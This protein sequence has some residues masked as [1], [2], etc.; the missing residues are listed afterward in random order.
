MK[1]IQTMSF[2]TLPVRNLEGQNLELP[3]GFESDRTIAIVA[4]QRWHQSLVDSWLP[5]LKELQTRQPEVQ[6]YEIPVLSSMYMFMR[7]MI[8]GGMAAAIPS[9]EV[10]ARTLTAY[11]DVGRVVRMLGLSDTSTITVLLVNRAGHILWQGYGSYD[12]QQAAA[13]E[14]AL[15]ASRS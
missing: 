5:W 12:S 13:L 3:S 4:F 7:W 11:T 2:P 1:K 6:V 15:Q 8:D 10:R 9:Q 14:E